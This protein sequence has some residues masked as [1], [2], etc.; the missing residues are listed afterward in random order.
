MP[1]RD[2]CQTD[3]RTVDVGITLREAARQLADEKLG[4][5]VVLGDD[6][7]VRG[8]VTDRDIAL[9]VLHE[10]LDPDATTVGSV[11][12]DDLVVVPADSMVRV[13]MALLRK[14][15]VR[16]LP[17][18]DAE[19]RLVGLIAWDDLLGIVARELSAVAATL[20]AEVKEA[21]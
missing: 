14:H 10:R 17:V 1:V 16:R 8:V 2:Y 9:R 15:S 12:S 21:S 13:A 3:V 20:F 18:L 19:A 5:L 7:R 6:G 4:A 11:L